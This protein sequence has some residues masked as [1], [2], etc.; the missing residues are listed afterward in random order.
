MTLYK[1]VLTFDGSGTS[2]FNQTETVGVK[3][4]IYTTADVLDDP[5]T[6]KITIY[7]PD[8]TVALAQTDMTKDETGTY[9]YNYTIASDA[10]TG[11]WNVSIEALTTDYTV[12]NIMFK[13]MEII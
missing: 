7:K 12:K 13:V 4:L 3:A 10:D 11:L 2:V 1:I 9:H 6:V 5:T 8:E